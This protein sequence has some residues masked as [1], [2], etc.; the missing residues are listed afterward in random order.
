[1]ASAVLTALITAATSYAHENEYYDG[2][3]IN[4][5]SSNM[6]FKILSSAINSLLTKEVY[7][8]ALGWN[9]ISS[10]V[11]LNL[12]WETP[13]VPTIS[14]MISV[15]G[16]KQD[17]GYYGI[18]R[19]YRADGSQLKKES[20]LNTTWWSVQVDMNTNINEYDDVS[21]ENKPSMEK[22]A[23]THEVGHALKLNH[24]VRNTNYADHNI[25]G[26]PYAIM[27]RTAREDEKAYSYSIQKHDKDCLIE[28]WG[29]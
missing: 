8:G 4:Y 23:F 1:M 10:N 13:G 24:T 7:E 26:F 5:S 12:F 14:S 3:Y 6:H 21:E 29:A 11:S 20:E 9:N 17:P 15:I 2:G 28:K 22:A 27:H 16:E 19:A 18:T 25:N